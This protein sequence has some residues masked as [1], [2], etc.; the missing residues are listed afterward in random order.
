MLKNVE[1]HEAHIAQKVQHQD[2]DLHQDV[3]ARVVVIM[4]ETHNEELKAMVRHQAVALDL[5]RGLLIINVLKAEELN[6]GR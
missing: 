2:V 6:P 4:V 1:A 5:I 3:K